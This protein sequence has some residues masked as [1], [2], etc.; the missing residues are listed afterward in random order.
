METEERLATSQQWL[1]WSVFATLWGLCF[2]TLVII[3]R[4]NGLHP[5]YKDLANYG[6]ELRPLKNEI[7]GLSYTQRENNRP[8]YSVQFGDLRTEN[9]NF[10]IFKTGL[11][12]VVKIQDLELAF[13]RYTS[14]QV[15]STAAYNNGKSSGTPSRL[16]LGELGRA[17]P[18]RKTLGRAGTGGV[19]PAIT[20][21][22]RPGLRKTT[23]NV[24]TIVQNLS[25]LMRLQDDLRLAVDFS[26]ASEIL[27]NDFEYKVFCDGNPVCSVKSKR[28]MMD[29]DRPEATLRGHVIIKTADGDILES[30]YVK[31]DITNQRFTAIRGYVLSHNGAR[32]IGSVICVDDKLNVVR[33]RTGLLGA[34]SNE[35]G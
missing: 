11:Y 6:A 31:W 35:N 22:I 17:E 34:R 8:V 28:L 14:A 18:D 2:L 16:D 33:K 4:N 20:I 26:N 12:K 3:T 27:V 21:G 23:A 15:A 7:K 32:T 9:N 25:S 10:G 13:Y 1:K 24:S 19:R 30:N 5:P 29:W